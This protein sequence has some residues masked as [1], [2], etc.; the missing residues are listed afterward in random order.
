MFIGNRFNALKI[1]KTAEAKRI[2]SVVVSDEK[3]WDNVELAINVFRSL[4]KLLRFVDGD[5]RPAIGFIHGGLMDARIELAQLLRNELELCI[6]VI[7]A[8]DFYMDGKL[9]SE[10]HLMAYYLN[11]YYFYSNRNGFI[12]S[13]KISGSVHKFIQRFYPDD[14]IQDKITGAEMLAYSEASGT[15]GNPGA[16]RQREKNNDS[17]NPAH[18]WNVWGSKAPYLQ[19]MK[20]KDGSAQKEDA[21]MEACEDNALVMLKV[22]FKMNLKA[23]KMWTAAPILDESDKELTSSEHEFLAS[24]DDHETEVS[25]NDVA[26]DD[27]SSD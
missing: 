17:F 1:S 5:K 22:G 6:P 18:W 3:F 10:L 9:D 24:D 14:Q 19:G 26:V 20:K 7:N 8:I 23:H 25:D 2:S 13:E 27:D 15:F 4:V 11:P 21:T 16:K 12:S